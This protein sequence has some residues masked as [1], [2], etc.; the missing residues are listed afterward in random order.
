MDLTGYIRI[1]FWGSHADTVHDGCTYCFA[2][3]GR[4]SFRVL[5]LGFGIRVQGFRFQVL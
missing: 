5:G 4:T 3:L 1:V 2:K